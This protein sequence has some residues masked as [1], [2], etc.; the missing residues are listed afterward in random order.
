MESRRSREAEIG[1][2]DED[3]AREDLGDDREGIDARVEHS[4][5]PWLPNPC[6][7]RMPFV[8]VLVPDDLHLANALPGK[9]LRGRVDRR[10]VTRVPGSVERNALRLG[11][12]GEV[13]DFA[14][15]DGRRLLHQDV[16]PCRDA[17]ARNLVPGR[18]RRGDRDRFEPFDF[19]EQLPPVGKVRS[20]PWPERLDVATRSNR[21]FFVIEGTCWSAAILPKPM[22]AI[23]ILRISASPPAT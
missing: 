19:A 13:V 1:G 18:G 4:E 20:T 11:E 10:I 3:G 22:M 8:D 6:L 2:A 23:L 16:E 14:Q 5:T 17:G 15:R 21:P 9:Q 12:A 7:A